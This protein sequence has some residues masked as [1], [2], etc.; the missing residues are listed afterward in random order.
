MQNQIM[1]Q[2]IAADTAEGIRNKRLPRKRWRDEV[3]RD[4]N[5]M[6]TKDRKWPVQRSTTDCSVGRGGGRGRRGGE[7]VCEKG[8]VQR[9][10]S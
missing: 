2:Q 1:P 5:L 4:L 9:R 7:V 3:E 10:V 6:G 8:A